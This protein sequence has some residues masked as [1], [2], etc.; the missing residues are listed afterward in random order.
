M[1]VS[2]LLVD[3]DDIA[4]EAMIRSLKKNRI[5]IEVV[6]AEDGFTA[7]LI[8]LGKHPVKTIARPYIVF[9]DLNMPRMDGFE[10]LNLIRGNPDLA[11]TVVYVL[12]TSDAESDLRQAYEKKIAGY[13]VKST[14]G[15][16][17][18]RL[19]HLMDAETAA[20]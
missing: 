15:P 18:R 14:V 4:R 20:D 2:I 9:L 1:T 5:S 6:E 10:F 19:A 3:D 17:F 11:D 13:M 12:T 8:L 7:L 16:D